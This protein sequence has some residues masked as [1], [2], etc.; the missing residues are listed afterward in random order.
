MGLLS[1][2]FNV[3][4]S[5]YAGDLILYFDAGQNLLDGYCREKYLGKQTEYNFTR[6]KP[7]E[8]FYKTGA[9]AKLGIRSHFALRVTGAI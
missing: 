1:T 6:R 3:L 8:S 4:R 5:D 7:P 9:G 2:V